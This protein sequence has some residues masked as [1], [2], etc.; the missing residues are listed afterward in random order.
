MFHF[1]LV[2]FAGKKNVV[3]DALSRRPHVAAVSIA[4]QHELDEMRDHY[5]TD[6]DFVEPYHALVRGEHPDPLHQVVNLEENEVKDICKFM[7][8]A[9]KQAQLAAKSGQPP[10]G[11][12]IVDPST[13]LPV[14]AGH[15]ETGGWMNTLCGL[16]SGQSQG[17]CS[18]EAIDVITSSKQIFYSWHPLRHA[19][20]VAIERAAESIKAEKV[21]HIIHR[22][23]SSGANTKRL[24]IN[25]SFV[26]FS[27]LSVY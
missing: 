14:A 2:H 26:S 4:Y 21:D 19:V 11:A 23:D 12:V 16:Q 25:E 10:N 18:S 9:V 1:Q 22:A 13:G 20:M 17:C 27:Y 3:A 15:D 24:R 8:A 6:E 7:G 5:N